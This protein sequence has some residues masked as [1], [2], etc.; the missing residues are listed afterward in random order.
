MGADGPTQAQSYIV[1]HPLEVDYLAN[2]CPD[3]LAPVGF[4][5]RS[6][7]LTS[8]FASDFVGQGRTLRRMVV[9][10]MVFS[11]KLPKNELWPVH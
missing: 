3:G 10:Q 7:A 8:H 11:W 5:S 2:F 9:Q 6:F 1:A 4:P